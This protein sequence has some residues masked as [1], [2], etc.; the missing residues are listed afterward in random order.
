MSEFKLKAGDRVFNDAVIAEHAE[1]KLERMRKW[2]HHHKLP[3]EVRA[4]DH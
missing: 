4:D 2:T 1:R 3:P